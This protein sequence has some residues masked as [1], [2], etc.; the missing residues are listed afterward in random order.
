[1]NAEELK[2]YTRWF[3]GW[4]LVTYL[5]LALINKSPLGRDDSDPS[6]WGMRSGVKPRIDSLTGCQYLEAQ[7]G[8]I[9]PRLDKSGAH[10][11][12]RL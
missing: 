3:G 11:G 7:S 2:K 9:T 8:G 4:L 6:E 12:C 1:M 5:V 10:V